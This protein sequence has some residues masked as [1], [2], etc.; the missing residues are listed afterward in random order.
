M[1]TIKESIIGRKGSDS[2]DV[3]AFLQDHD[4]VMM[5]ER[6]NP[7]KKYLYRFLTTTDETDMAAKYADKNSYGLPTLYPALYRIRPGGIIFIPITGFNPKTGFFDNSNGMMI[8][9]IYRCAFHFR[10]K[11]LSELNTYCLVDNLQKEVQN[12]FCKLIW[13]LK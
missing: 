5:T 8:T 3:E 10:Y 2:R 11:N 1:K 7:N 13:E 4:I 12:R 6:K 9:K